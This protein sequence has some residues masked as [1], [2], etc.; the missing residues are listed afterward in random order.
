MRENSSIVT[1]KELYTSLTVK[2]KI[3]LTSSQFNSLFKFIDN[4]RNRFK[5]ITDRLIKI[6]ENKIEDKEL[7]KIM[8]SMTKGIEYTIDWNIPILRTETDLQSDSEKVLKSSIA[9]SKCDFLG[10]Y[11]KRDGL[12]HLL[13]DTGEFNL[14]HGEK[15]ILFLEG[16]MTGVFGSL[17][18]DGILIERGVLPGGWDSIDLIDY[19]NSEKNNE[20]QESKNLQ[21]CDT[22]LT[23]YT[24]NSGSLND[25]SN[26]TKHT[27]FFNLLD[28]E[29]DRVK[30][31]S[32][33]H[34]LKKDTVLELN[35][36]KILILEEE[37]EKI[38]KKKNNNISTDGLRGGGILYY[39]QFYRTL[40]SQ[41][42]IKIDNEIKN[43]PYDSKSKK[44]SFI[45]II[46]QENAIPSV[47]L[48]GNAWVCSVR[49]GDS[50]RFIG[51][52]V[53][54]VRYEHNF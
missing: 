23:Y 25:S 39:K 20:N 15:N 49:K 7:N 35:D 1:L 12:S 8:E 9:N 13:T 51:E 2:N 38:I 44:N 4:D 47:N 50:L 22:W 32:N 14:I 11:S 27:I 48:I 10:F 46:N 36:K 43:I 42:V 30:T 34:F 26:S 54:L 3:F 29:K 17:E 28:K 24:D 16:I 40:L 18:P 6:K 5:A 31:N 45:L 52:N 19:E 33:T 37:I 53:E 41:L 21:D